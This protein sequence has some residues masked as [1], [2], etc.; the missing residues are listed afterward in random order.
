VNVNWIEFEAMGETISIRQNF[1]ASRTPVTYDVFD[2]LGSHV[3]RIDAV[4]AQ[5]VSQKVRALVKNG[6][7]YYVKSRN[8]SA[9]IRV[10]K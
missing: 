10:M 5:E 3:G 1:A 7:S 9:T 2:M 4:N 6:G 8:G